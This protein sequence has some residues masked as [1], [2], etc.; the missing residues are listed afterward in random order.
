MHPSLHDPCTCPGCPLLLS[1]SADVVS[2]C[3]GHTPQLF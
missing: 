2:S 1:S 3:V